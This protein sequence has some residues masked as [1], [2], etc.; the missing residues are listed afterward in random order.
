MTVASQMSPTKGTQPQNHV[1]ATKQPPGNQTG[2]EP[3]P[4]LSCS[5]RCPNNIQE[6]E[7]HTLTI[8]TGGTTFPFFTITTPLIEERLVRDEQTNELYLALTSTMVLKRKQKILHVPLAF[9]NNLTVD[10]L[11]DLRA[12]VSATAQNEEDT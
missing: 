8:S 7:S 5:K 9:K 4:F 12:F 6:S 2:N 10:A 11:L 3:V 1:I